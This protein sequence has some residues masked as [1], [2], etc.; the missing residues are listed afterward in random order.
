[1]RVQVVLDMTDDEVQRAF[2]VAAKLGFLR[3]NPRSPIRREEYKEAIRFM[4][5]RLVRGSVEEK[6]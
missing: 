5:L 6:R 4:V 3:E 2:T 1:M